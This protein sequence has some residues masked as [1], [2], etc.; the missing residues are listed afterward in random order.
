MT[1]SRENG[2][3]CNNTAYRADSD[4]SETKQGCRRH[5]NLQAALFLFC[6]IMVYRGAKRTRLKALLS[7]LEKSLFR[8]RIQ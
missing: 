6:L 3:P 2:I 8:K 7:S 5:F 4:P 1:S